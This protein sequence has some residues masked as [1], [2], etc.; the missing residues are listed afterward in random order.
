MLF[1]AGFLVCLGFGLILLGVSHLVFAGGEL[2]FAILGVLG[3][4]VIA[5]GGILL[6]WRLFTEA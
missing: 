2:P 4:L 5:S 1:I 3:S 6:W